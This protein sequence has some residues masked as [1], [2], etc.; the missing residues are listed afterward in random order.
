M[1][2]EIFRPDPTVA[3]VLR[4]QSGTEN[5]ALRRSVFLFPYRHGEG[6]YLYHSLTRQCFRVDPALY[7][8]VLSGAAVPEAEELRVL[9]ENWFLVPEEKDE[10][11]LYEGLQRLLRLRGV[12]RRYDSY[13]ILP[14]TACNARCFYCVENGVH[15]VTMSPETTEQTIAF[16]LRTRDPERQ[17]HLIWFGGEPLVAPQVIDRVSAALTEAGV[18]FASS[19]V[20]NGIL[21]DEDVLSRMTGAWRVRS[22]QI[23]LDGREEDYNSRKNY[24][25]P[26]PSAYRVLLENL[27]RLSETKIRVMLRCNIDEDN[28]DGLEQMIDDLA[29]ALPRKRQFYLYFSVLF[30]RKNSDSHAALLRRGLEARVYARDQGFPYVPLTSPHR[31]RTGFCYAENPYGSTLISPEGQLYNCN[32]FL[33]GTENGNVREGIT[34][35][36]YLKT[37]VMPESV[38]EKCRDCCFL[39]NCTSFTRCPLSMRQCREA[40]SLELEY[41]LRCELER[42]EKNR[43]EPEEHGE[44]ENLIC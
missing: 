23:T 10:T 3:G 4:K 17:T 41:D 14:T 43:P 16:I 25:H 26:Y 20:S 7:E 28:V 34:R 19:M 37:F 44:E 42:K 5:T 8:A 36:E 22:I 18:D 15:F 40:R 38:A 32:L 33:P 11:A 13:T 31:L 29:A 27:R 12:R 9:A 30:S 39:P 6:Y 21:I 2:Q 24:R 35:P 1:L